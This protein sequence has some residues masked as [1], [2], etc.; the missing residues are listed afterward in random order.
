[1]QA[2]QAV[3][4]MAELKYPLSVAQPGVEIADDKAQGYRQVRN[5]MPITTKMVPNQR[6][7]EM[8]SPKNHLPA[9]I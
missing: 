1:M 3:G 6:S 4:V 5:M 8:A 2:Q 9:T 7:A